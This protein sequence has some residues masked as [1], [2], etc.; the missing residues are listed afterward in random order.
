MSFFTYDIPHLRSISI[1]GIMF[2]E[3]KG[4]GEKTRSHLLWTVNLA[5]SASSVHG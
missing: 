2:G 5:E 4:P 3:A 1:G